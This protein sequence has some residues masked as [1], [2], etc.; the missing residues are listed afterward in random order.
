MRTVLRG[1]LPVFAFLLIISTCSLAETAAETYKT[2]CAMCHGPAG[3]GDTTLGQNLHAKDL[4]DRVQPSSLKGGGN[5]H[6]RRSNSNA[7]PITKH[8]SQREP[9]LTHLSE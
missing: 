9:K 5:P 2:T 8:F 4:K 6:Q 7:A 1:T 3:K